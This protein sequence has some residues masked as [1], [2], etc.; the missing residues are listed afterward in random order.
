MKFNLP[1]G[2]DVVI[3][4]RMKQHPNT[5]SFMI[6]I[7]ILPTRRAITISWIYDAARRLYVHLGWL[8]IVITHCGS[9]VCMYYCSLRLVI[10]LYALLQSPFGDSVVCTVAVSQLVVLLCVQFGDSVVCAVAV[11]VW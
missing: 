2:T 8:R 7:R 10:L 9:V 4:M 5:S 3:C 1:H 6:G 11:S